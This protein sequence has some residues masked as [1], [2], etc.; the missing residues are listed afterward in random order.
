MA[1]LISCRRNEEIDGGK[2][3]LTT[4]TGNLITAN[5]NDILEVIPSEDKEFAAAVKKLQFGETTYN[6]YKKEVEHKEMTR[7]AAVR[8][9]MGESPADG[10]A[11]KGS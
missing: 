9:A 11:V 6:D 1:K 3:N 2:Y 8:A 4:G 10:F 7:E 5:I